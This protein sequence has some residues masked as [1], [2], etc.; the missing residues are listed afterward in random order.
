MTPPDPSQRAGEAATAA[1]L[2]EGYDD[3]K[4]WSERF[5]YSASDADYFRG[6]LEGLPLRGARV[7]E[8]GFGGG[9]FLAWARDAG[10]EVEGTELLPAAVDAARMAGFTAH[11]PDLAALIPARTGGFDLIVAFDVL[12]HIE[13]QA[14]I[15]F[16]RQVRDL[17]K[18]AGYL[19]ARV[20]NGQSP[21]GLLHQNGDLTHITAL[22]VPVFQHLA[23]A[24]GFRVV[25]AANAFRT[26]PRGSKSGKGG[27]TQFRRTLRWRLRL[28]L[29]DRMTDWLRYLYGIPPMPFDPNLTVVMQAEERQ[30]PGGPAG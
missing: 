14:L 30:P 10:A 15:G 3:L 25:R 23:L 5:V 9:G 7:L 27:W 8:I 29:R 12:E 13:R 6:E 26:V 20:P 1:A 17:L 16:L 2:Y 19:L 28:A 11:G 18:P 4:G 21:F 22:S 24:T